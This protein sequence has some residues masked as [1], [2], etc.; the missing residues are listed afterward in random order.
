MKFFIFSSFLMMS[1]FTLFSQTKG[2]ILDAD[3]IP[4]NEVSRVFI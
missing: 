3:N 2:V 1:F 4:I